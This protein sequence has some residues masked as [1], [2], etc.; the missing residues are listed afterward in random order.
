MKTRYL[1]LK[2]AAIAGML[3]LVGIAISGCE[4]DP[5]MLM[6]GCPEDFYRPSD[7]VIPPDSV[8]TN[9]SPLEEIL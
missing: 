9:L 3:A 1:K 7:S 8:P 6:Y 5:I 2:G 4:K